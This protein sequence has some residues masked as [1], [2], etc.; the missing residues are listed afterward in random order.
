MHMI[1]DRKFYRSF[2]SMVVVLILQNIITLSVNLADNIMLGAYSE[3]ALAGVAAVNQIQFV[4]QQILL[5]IGEAVVILGTQYFGKGEMGPVKRIS[6]I[7]LHFALAVAAGLFLAVCLW[8][9]MLVAA[10]TPDP[11]I[12]EQGVSY[13]TI[14]R[15]TY[16]FF[17]VTQILLATLRSTG[18]VRIALGLSVWSLAVNCCINYTL[19]YGHFGAPRLGVM[20]AA[21]GTLTA[22][23]SELLLLLFYIAKKE[24]HL[25][26]RLAN[27]LHTDRSLR[28]DYF[29]VLLPVLVGSILWGMNNAVQNSILGHMSTS[30][31]AAN[32]VAS[33]MFLL[34]KSMAVGASSTASVFIGRAVGEGNQGKVKQYARTMQVLF[35]A[36]GVV[37]SVVLF[38]VRIPILSLY[39]L[40][41]E[42]MELADTFLL[43]LCVIIIGMSYQM[44]T[45]L[46]IVRGGGD[47]RYV[48]IMD[49]ISIWCIVL[50]LSYV[51]AFVLNASPI[52]VLW[53][54]NLD[55]IFKCVPAFLKCNFGHWA[56]KLTRE[57]R[58]DASESG[59]DCRLLLFDLDGTLL[60]ND[61][62]VSPAVLNAVRRCREKGILIGIATS[63]GEQIAMSFIEE[64]R[65]DVL[66]ASGGAVVK[67]RGQYVYRAEFTGEE[68]KRMI[69]AAREVC[70][71]DCEITIDTMDSHYWNY[72]IDPKEQDPS[73]GESI[74]TDYA[75]FEEPSLKMCVEIFEEEQAK[76]LA[77]L[78]EE[79]D[80]VRFSDGYW[81]KFTKKTATK[82]YAIREACRACGIRTE[83]ITAFGDD[84]A[85]M[86]MLALCGRG[87]AMGN[88]VDAVKEKAD[89][90]IGSNEEDGIAAYLRQTFLC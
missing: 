81:Y 47:T 43:I 14:I 63:R 87:I 65:P 21:I 62:T 77:G 58:A 79:C 86:G 67:Y 24:K 66:I 15:Y 83:E 49:F 89:L 90:V 54:L 34:V 28:R 25:G 4:Y 10:F 17:A 82:E 52:V 76:R 1:R 42:T 2:F 38:L 53:C 50:P 3:P 46:G 37:S 5:G 26:L 29:K 71:M 60:R 12:I 45:N 32:S 70:G 7:A 88:A 74:Y 9:D 75:D 13:L 59:S 6:S 73:W 69:A 57:N 33:T 36:I 23:V 72:R 78:L 48:M 31:I 68:T 61:K 18:T 30:A 19:I 22:R 11:Q 16:L 8:P 44:P 80:C 41:P 39:Q 85:D 84:Y 35:L 64:L 20:G 51:M 55:Q 56:K 27:Y 40:E